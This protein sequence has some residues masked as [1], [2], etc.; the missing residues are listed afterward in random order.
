MR[1]GPCAALLP[2]TL[3]GACATTSDPSQGGFLSGVSGLSSGEYKRRV[4]DRTAEL[5]RMRR[6]E[7]DAVARARAA[8]AAIETRERQIILLRADIAA[9]D[10][11]AEREGLAVQQ[12]RAGNAAL[13]AEN[14]RL[15]GQLGTLRGRLSQL[16][17]RLQANADSEDY[18]AARREYQSVEAAMGV[19]GQQLERRRK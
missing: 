11:L 15:I 6:D 3:L 12:T 1:F 2:L 8:N 13:A 14:R 19:L 10:R 17:A 9:L 4:A 5:E 18:A 7:A 16:R